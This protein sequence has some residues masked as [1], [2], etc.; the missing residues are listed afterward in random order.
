MKKHTLAVT[1]E[2]RPGVLTRVTTM[3]RRRGYNIESLAVGATENPAISRITIEVTGDERI[4]EQVTKQ[5]YKLVEVIKINDLTDARS[6]DRELV[7]IK[8]KADNSVRADIVQIVDIFRARIVDIGRDSLIIEV[9]GDS[10]KIEAI[11]DSLRAFGIIE[12]VRTG[13][14]AMIRGGK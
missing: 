8:V 14:I 9:T 7:L 5:L 4:I 6:V 13:K 10:R 1:V 3:F 2:N 12:M 11:E